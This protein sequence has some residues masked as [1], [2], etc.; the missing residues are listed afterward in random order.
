MTH[1]LLPQRQ[2]KIPLPLLGG[3][4]SVILHDFI[5][6]NY[7]KNQSD[8]YPFFLIMVNYPI[9]SL[10]Y[11]ILYFHMYFQYLYFLQKYSKYN[12]LTDTVAEYCSIH[13]YTDCVALFWCPSTA[14][15]SGSTWGGLK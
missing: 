14:A 12:S 1:S 13:F 11:H 2:G 4:F 10:N 3:K 8:R 6:K 15:S 9:F 7:H 5:R